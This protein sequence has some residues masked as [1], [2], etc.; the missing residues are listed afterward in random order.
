MK[1]LMF[2]EFSFCG[3]TAQSIITEKEGW[4]GKKLSVNKNSP[5]VFK[6]RKKE[7][8]QGKGKRGKRYHV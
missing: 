1:V 5:R 8:W 4:D 2:P 7:D 6:E 3:M